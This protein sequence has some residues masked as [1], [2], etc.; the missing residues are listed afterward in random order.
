MP[1]DI[2]DKIRENTSLDNYG[3]LADVVEKWKSSNPDGNL[4][5]S[6]LDEI[7]RGV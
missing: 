6:Q 3:K 4:T 7:C 2:S 1:D 5:D